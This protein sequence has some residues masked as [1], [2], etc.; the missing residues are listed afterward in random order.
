MPGNLFFPAPRAVWFR[1]GIDPTGKEIK[2]DVTG[3]AIKFVDRHMDSFQLAV[4]RV[5]WYP[6]GTFSKSPRRMNL[7]KTTSAGQ[8]LSALQLFHC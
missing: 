4:F 3:V 8:R 2:E 1:G 6:K 7:S 5:Q